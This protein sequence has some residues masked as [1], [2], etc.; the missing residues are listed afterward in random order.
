MRNESFVLNAALEASVTKQHKSMQM[1]IVKLLEKIM[2][3]ELQRSRLM[4]C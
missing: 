1:R 3:N 2:I 4:P